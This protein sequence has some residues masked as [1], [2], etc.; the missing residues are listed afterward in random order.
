MAEQ[1]RESDA[2]AEALSIERLP[3]RRPNPIPTRRGLGNLLSEM[4]N[5]RADYDPER[6]QQTAQTIV[7]QWPFQS[8]GLERRPRLITDPSMIQ[9]RVMPDLP[10]SQS[11]L[12]IMLKGDESI[13][14]DFISDLNRYASSTKHAYVEKEFKQAV[15]ELSALGPGSFKYYM[16]VGTAAGGGFKPAT[17]RAAIRNVLLMEGFTALPEAATMHPRTRERLLTEKA[18]K[19]AIS[20]GK[21]HQGFMFGMTGPDYGGA[22]TVATNVLGPSIGLRAPRGVLERL[23]RREPTRQ[24]QPEMTGAPE[25]ASSKPLTQA[26]KELRALASSERGSG[27]NA[28]ERAKTIVEMLKDNLSENDQ[29][30]MLSILN[31]DPGSFARR[32]AADPAKAAVRAVAVLRSGD[33]DIDLTLAQQDRRR[34]AD[35]IEEAVTVK[36][37]KV[38]VTR[39]TKALEATSH[40]TQ[41]AAESVYRDEARRLSKYVPGMKGRIGPAGPILAIAAI[42]SA[43]MFAAGMA[44]EEAA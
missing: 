1:M 19:V 36:K 40:V 18:A 3:D 14:R 22:H 23:S 34:L 37:G 42:L 41:E 8:L 16:D 29:M 9:V 35:A 43:G 26:I 33:P 13:T 44:R 28:A 27:T 20:Q 2:L 30:R 4:S 10:V 15:Q 25:Q 5:V 32:F 17:M 21:G 12:G 39:A 7:D 24:F 31:E 6:L 38:S 11:R